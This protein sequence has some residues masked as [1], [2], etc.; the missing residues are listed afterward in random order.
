M[1]FIRTARRTDI[2]T[3]RNIERSSGEAFRHI[4]G[5]EWIADDEPMN[6][7][8]YGDLIG[9]DT[10]LIAELDR[11]PV[12][13][14]AGYLHGRSFHIAQLS[15]AYGMQG[16]GLGTSLMTRAQ[17]MALSLGAVEI[18]LTT[19][20]DLPFNEKFY[21]SIGFRRLGEAELDARLCDILRSEAAF[22]LPRRRR[23]A[24]QKDLADIQVS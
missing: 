23:C 22:G 5:L 2:Q 10:V 24:M 20:R 9:Q 14:L 12:G 17:D 19:F 16:K 4:A 18:T 13:F 3:I 15:V 21:A 6:A 8:A 7:D 11:S 1:T